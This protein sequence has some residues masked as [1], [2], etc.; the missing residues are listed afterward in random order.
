MEARARRLG[1]EG[2]V[3]FHDRFVSETEL[4]EFLS[5]ADIYVTPYLKETQITSGTLA[6][7]VGAGKAVVS[8]PYWYATEL[9][10]DERGILVPFRDAPAIA[11]AV[12]GLLDDDRRRAGYSE[13]AAAFAH[14]MKWPVVARS[15]LASFARARAQHA[16]G[17]AARFRRGLSRSARPSCPSRA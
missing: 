14:D 13:R 5:A 2:N 12:I 15:Y 17:F 16:G 7:A 11:N 10:A 3:I 8:T 6:Y 4:G 9:L 1:V